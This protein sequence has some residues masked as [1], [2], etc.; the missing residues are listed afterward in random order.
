M[1][2]KIYDARIC[3]FPQGQGGRE[4]SFT[5]SEVKLGIKFF[6]DNGDTQYSAIIRVN[7]NKV[8]KL[9]DISKAKLKFINDT[10]ASKFISKGTSFEIFEGARRIGVGKWK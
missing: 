6:N 7:K 5:S 2:N 8:I 4:H 10:D 9:G 1:M 3:L